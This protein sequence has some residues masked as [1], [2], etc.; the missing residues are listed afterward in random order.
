MKIH[1]NTFHPII[2]FLLT[3]M[4]VLAACAP[5]QN[6][7]PAASPSIS[8]APATSTAT[9][10][11][12]TIT[13]TPVVEPTSTPAPLRRCPART[14]GAEL[15]GYSNLTELDVAILDYVNHGGDPASLKSL[16][17][18]TDSL[19]ISVAV[20][21]LDGDALEEIVVSGSLR[22]TDEN[23]SIDETYIINIYQ[24]GT[25]V[26]R[27]AQSYLP[28]FNYADVDIL[29]VDQIFKNEPPFVIVAFSQISGWAIPYRAIGWHEGQ[30]EM[31]D[32]GGGIIGSDIML[33]DQDDDG[34]KEVLILSDNS[35]SLAGGVSREEISVFAWTGKKFWYDHSVFPPGS[36]RVHYL[37]DASDAS[38]KGDLMMAIALYE[39]AARDPDLPSYFT[40]YEFTENQTEL[41]EPYQ[42]AFAFFRIAVI[43]LSQNRPDMAEKIIHEM[44]E[45]FP[46]GTPG[47]EF[48][49]VAK[50]LAARYEVSHKPITSCLEA[51][52]IL[53]ADYPNVLK[54]H[55]GDWGFMNVSYSSTSEFCK[56]N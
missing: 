49:V 11:I 38:K 8:P 9:R 3:S 5:V 10:A 14:G 24:C 36:D 47:S 46:E 1:R 54:G 7:P 55:I 2:F 28:T 15:K 34:I 52:K 4:I 6:V 37:S 31:I 42:K 25:S 12:P 56:L 35:T 30:W 23:F 51:V 39:I 41:S 18:S 44:S 48:V 32:L 43:W 26:Y 17:V 50:D 20:V 40:T 29:F 16:L 53:D 13:N 19:R 27:L 33:Y 45:T 22:K 21:D